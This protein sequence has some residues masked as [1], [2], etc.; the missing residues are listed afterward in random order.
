MHE[1]LIETV[2]KI[3]VNAHSYCYRD[4]SEYYNDHHT[5]TVSLMP[6]FTNNIQLIWLKVYEVE[7]GKGQ[8]YGGLLGDAKDLMEQINNCLAAS[9]L[10]SAYPWFMNRPHRDTS[11]SWRR[12]R[13]IG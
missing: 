13:S 12:R 3:V 7:A 6:L 1:P 11:N 2:W 9:R 8:L 4:F 5:Y 10:G